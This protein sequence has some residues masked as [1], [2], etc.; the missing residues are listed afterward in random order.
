MEN[1]GTFAPP[2]FKLFFV[3]YCKIFLPNHKIILK[4]DSHGTVRLRQVSRWK[5][6]TRNPMIAFTVGG[7]NKSNENL[8]I[9]AR[10][11]A[12][13]QDR[14]EQWKRNIGDERLI[15]FVRNYSELHD[16]STANIVTYVTKWSCGS[17]WGRN[18]KKVS[19]FIV[20]VT[21]F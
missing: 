8:L 12:S 9:V 15:G 11:F 20:F 13:D 16:F 10:W 14:N 6:L 19:G 3:R 1:Y 5:S 2:T 4:L 21:M 18:F 17:K 7:L